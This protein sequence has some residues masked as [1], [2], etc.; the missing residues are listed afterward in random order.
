[1]RAISSNVILYDNE[2]AIG[3]ADDNDMMM[4]IFKLGELTNVC[5]SQ[6]HRVCQPGQCHA[7]ICGWRANSAALPAAMPA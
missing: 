4:T 5:V 7:A 1:M 3:V 2:F 6:E